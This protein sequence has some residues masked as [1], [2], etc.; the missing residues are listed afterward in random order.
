LQIERR[1]RDPLLPP[2]FLLDR[3]RAFGL[4]AIA[5]SACATAMTSVVLALHLQQELGWS[6]LQTSAS[7]VPFALV[8]IA[9]GRAAGPIIGRYCSPS[10]S[11]SAVM[12]LRWPRRPPRSPS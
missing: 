2:R 8:L 12:P 4:A 10:C 7:F 5:L 1:A 11:R 9:S 3:Q 6:Q